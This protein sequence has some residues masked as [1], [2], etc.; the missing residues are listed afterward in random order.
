M[1]VGGGARTPRTTPL[2]EDWDSSWWKGGKGEVVE[3]NEF[4]ILTVR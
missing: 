1:R 4:P 2:F 3:E